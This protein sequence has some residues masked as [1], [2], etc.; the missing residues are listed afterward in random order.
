MIV[1]EIISIAKRAMTGSPPNMDN[2]IMRI[3]VSVATGIDSL[4]YTKTQ[5]SLKV[6]KKI[7]MFGILIISHTECD[8]S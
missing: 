2:F 6:K 5:N 3:N 4:L 1:T 7:N 8:L